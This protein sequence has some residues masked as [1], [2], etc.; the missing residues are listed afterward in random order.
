MWTQKRSKTSSSTSTV[1]QVSPQFP[2]NG[3]TLVEEHNGT[4]KTSKVPN[5][6]PV[7]GSFK[8]NNVKGGTGGHG[9]DGRIAGDGG[10]GGGPQ[11]KMKSSSGNWEFKDVEGG[12]GGNGGKGSE[13]SGNA[14]MGEG[15]VFE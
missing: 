4:N 1:V 12:I 13:K 11:F 3:H 7:K 10:V 15:P 6:N 9:G 5:S 14:G 8:F 2:G